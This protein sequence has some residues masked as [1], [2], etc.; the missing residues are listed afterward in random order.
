MIAVS[1]RSDSFHRLSGYLT[2]GASRKDTSRV[3]WTSTRNLPTGNPNIASHLMTAT[4]DLS[5]RCKKPVYHLIL[6]WDKSDNVTP[7]NMMDV[8]DTT[9]EHIGLALHETVMV[10]HKDR[11]HPHLHM[12]I[13]RVS[14]ETGKAWDMSH[15]YRAI[16]EVLRTKEI[17]H[18]FKQTP[19]RRDKSRAPNLAEL[20]IAEREE[21]APVRRMSKEACMKLRDKL[22]PSFEKALSWEDLEHRL[23]LKRYDLVAAGS[24]IRIARDGVY[25]KLS[26]S[27]PPEMTSKKLHHKLGDLKKYKQ[28]K[29]EKQKQRQRGLR[30]KHRP[31]LNIEQ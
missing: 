31:S 2:R 7:Q 20:A 28:K 27:L 18:G 19:S 16:R 6:S 13:N 11:E 23:A 14:M 3:D 8:A 22:A 24:G 15:D 30:R 5:K 9:L 1:S 29:L 26:D 12:M 10:A 25:A 4:A 21:R 17:E